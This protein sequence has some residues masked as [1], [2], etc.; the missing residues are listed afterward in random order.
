MDQTMLFVMCFLTGFCVL[1]SSGSLLLVLWQQSSLKSLRRT[2]AALEEKA[3]AGSAEFSDAAAEAAG[4]RPD[5]SLLQQRFANREAA[6][7]RVPEKYRYVA[8]LAR[9]GLGAEEVADVLDV[10]V[11]EAEQMLSLARASA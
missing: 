10:S 11:N 4:P 6:S 8:R 9:S 5:R 7:S 2:V 3:A 1:V